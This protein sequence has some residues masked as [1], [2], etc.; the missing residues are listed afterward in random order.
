L[1]KDVAD[2]RDQRSDNLHSILVFRSILFYAWYIPSGLLAVFFSVIVS[3]FLPLVWRLSVI[4]YWQS[5]VIEWLRLSCGVRYS[6][7]GAGRTPA[8]PYVVVSN[9]QG[10]WEAFCFQTLF[11]PLIVVVKKELLRVPLF[12]WALATLRPIAIQ[13]D[14]P[15]Q[16]AGKIL[17]EGADR[18]GRGLS[19]LLFP[20]GTRMAPGVLGRYKRTSLGLASQNCVPVVPVVHNSGDCWPARRFIKYPGIIRVVIGE[21]IVVGTQIPEKMNEIVSWSEITLKK[22]RE[23]NA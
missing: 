15:R 22:I 19:V 21:P 13:R 23:M 11:H 5:S 2:S 4:G 18:L 14:K 17:T 10:Q 3:P 9:H 6:V 8:P 20:E 16:A 7:E 12:G 1:S